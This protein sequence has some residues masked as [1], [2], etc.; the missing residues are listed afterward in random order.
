M[1]TL[2]LSIFDGDTEKNILRS[3]V[4]PALKHSG[5]RIVLLVRVDP[6]GARVPYYTKHFADRNVL[7]E[8]LPH[9]TTRWEA[10]LFH[11]SWNTLPTRSAAVKRHDLYL[12]HR[13][14]VRYGFECLVGFMGQFRWWRNLIRAAYY[15]M[16]DDY[17]ADLFAKYRPDALFAPNMFSAEDCRLLRAAR[18]RGIRTL[19][20]AKSWDVPTTRGFTRVKAD[21]ILVFNDINREEIVRIGDYRPEHVFAV[22]FPQ[23]DV[24]GDAS[25]RLSRA[26]FC[27]EMGIAP[28]K[29]IILFAV[30][31][32]FKNPF[33]HEIMEDLDRAAGAGRFVRPIH[34]IARF[35]P[36]YPSRGE[37]LTGLEHFTLDRPGSYFSSSLERALDAP[38]AKTFQWTYT[39]KDIA[40]LANSV[41]HSAV[42]VNTEST[43]TLDATALD[44]PVVLIG[45]DGRQQLPPERS[46]IR[47]YD[48]E[49]LEAV[50]ETGGVV[51]ARS[52]DQ[53][54][55]AINEY[56]A[57]PSA[58]TSERQLLK[59]RL[60]YRSD[61]RASRRIA[62]HV[63]AMLK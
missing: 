28:E 2:F 31:G 50:L 62:E 10:Y 39:D 26:E 56:L 49:H 5:H 11:L 38:S 22:G 54:V 52:Q 41:L 35:H 33:S 60:L 21:D 18:K 23:F 43:M 48:R 1:K 53:L 19:T 55:G 14:R 51:L 63:L 16:P 59:D 17:C 27:R 7:I 32:D 36:K 8:P 61:G 29:E 34:F 44:R 46:L 58:R 47:N 40:H 30:P 25:I 9:A 4:L 6:E 15:R 42:V 45:F 37:S 3:G 12:A 57:N 24:Y 20:M 13:N